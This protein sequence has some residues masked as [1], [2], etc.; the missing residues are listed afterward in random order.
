MLRAVIADASSAASCT[1]HVCVTHVLVF[2][3]DPNVEILGQPHEGRFLL[4][5]TILF[6]QLFP[7]ALPI[8]LFHGSRIPTSFY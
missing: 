6:L 4:Q 5:L 2:D 1:N 3:M 8:S 7:A